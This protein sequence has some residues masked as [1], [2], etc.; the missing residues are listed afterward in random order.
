MYFSLEIPDKNMYFHLP[1]DSRPGKGHMNQVVFWLSVVAN[2]L[3]KNLV[4]KTTTLFC[5]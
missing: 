1:E 2:D 3:P 4:V 5:S